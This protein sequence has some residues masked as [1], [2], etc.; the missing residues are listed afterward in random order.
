[1]KVLAEK[2]RDCKENKREKMKVC[3]KRL[4]GLAEHLGL[5]IVILDPVWQSDR[6]FWSWL[7]RFELALRMELAYSQHVALR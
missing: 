7:D 3:A 6:S 2:A 4:D 1:M 5:H